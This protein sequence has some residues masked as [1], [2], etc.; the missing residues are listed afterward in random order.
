[1]LQ[2]KNVSLKNLEDEVMNALKRFNLIRIEP[3]TITFLSIDP[4]KGTEKDIWQR[5]DNL[6]TEQ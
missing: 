1:M 3:D 2:D 4:V 5:E 6:R